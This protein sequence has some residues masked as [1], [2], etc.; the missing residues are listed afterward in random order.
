MLIFEKRLFE[1][2]LH[3]LPS[4]KTLDCS[5]IGLELPWEIGSSEKLILDCCADCTKAGRTRSIY[6]YEP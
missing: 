3:L 4:L 5:F 6:M 2:I 1:E